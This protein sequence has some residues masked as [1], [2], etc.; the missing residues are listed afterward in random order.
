MTARTV[1]LSGYAAKTC[2][3]AIHNR[4]D[5]TV[6]KQPVEVP[7]DVQRLFDLGNDHE[8]TIFATWLANGQDVVDLRPLD[9]CKADH[10]AA[11]LQTLRD[12]HAVV[13]GGR[14]PDDRRGGR[15]GKPDVLLR[16]AEGTGYHPCDVKAHKVIGRD[17]D[18]GLV[19]SLNDP[20]LAF[21]AQP[22]QGLR[23]R[24][25]DLLQLAHYW[26]MLQACGHQATA[27]W[28]A[29]VGTDDASLPQ[30]A[31]YD[32][33]EPIFRTFSRSEAKAYRS[34]LERYDHEHDF[35]V[36][37]AKVAQQ[38][39]GASSDPQPLVAPVGQQ[40]CVGC[41]WAPVCVD[42]LPVDNLSRE[43]LGSL[44]VRE[45]LALESAGVFNV[46]DLIDADLDQL[47]GSAYA[48]ETSHI[49]G[50]ARRLRKAHLSAELAQ[51]G[52]VLR[53]KADGVFGV[54]RAEVEIDLDMECDRDGRVYLWGVL[55]TIGGTSE[56]VPFLDLHA[57]NDARE[58]ALTVRC[59]DWLATTHPDALV[60]HYSSVEKSKA[61]R[62]L[63]EQIKSYSGTSAD[64]DRWVD[65]YPAV[66]CCLESRN[67]LGLKVVATLGAGFRWR[68][69]DP[70]GLQSQDWLEEAR[71]GDTKACQR[72]LDY[73]EDDVRA[74]LCVREWLEHQTAPT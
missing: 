68:D 5:V 18:G 12:G 55:V 41:T 57:T 24:E 46:D 6:P 61:N 7:D 59:F 4:F 22:K 35:R 56:F 50:R 69:E 36:R 65:L 21:A 71:A 17:H 66:K 9:D 74:T 2:A 38:R 52:V 62:I 44:S 47:L 43:L 11:T 27:P 63:G 3:R 42:V 28:G 8:A 58:R 29:I 26:R 70:G 39:T 60:Y 51:A 10:I 32:L 13:L 30:L 64:P 48:D 49:W 16:E 25:N 1:L 33:T 53:L 37:V 45:Y 19:S 40:D 20:A 15:T 54:P 14:L 23:Y 34:A 73:N 31:W 67:G 72:I